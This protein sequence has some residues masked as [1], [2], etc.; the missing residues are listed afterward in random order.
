TD[1][2]SPSLTR[3]GN[4]DSCTSQDSSATLTCGWNSGSTIP[5]TTTPGSLSVSV[6]R[7]CLCR[8]EMVS[9]DLIATNTGLRWTLV[10]KSRSTKLP[11]HRAWT[12]TTPPPFTTYRPNQ[13]GSRSR[14]TGVDQL[15]VR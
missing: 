2:S 11:S 10:S 4:W 1:C 8:V 3:P 13:A 7:V 6:I 9:C 12:R 5:R 14:V 15:L